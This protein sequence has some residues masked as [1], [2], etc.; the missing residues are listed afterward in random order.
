MNKLTAFILSLY[1]ELLAFTALLIAHAY[2]SSTFEITFAFIT[3]LFVI[4]SIKLYPRK[5]VK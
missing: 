5:S 1:F 4:I 3:L 2:N